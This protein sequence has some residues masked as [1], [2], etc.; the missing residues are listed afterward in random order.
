MIVKI[1][2]GSVTLNGAASLNTINIDGEEQTSA[3]VVF[4][5]TSAAKT[6]LAADVVTA[7]ASARTKATRIVGNALANTI[8]GG[9]GKDT[10]YGGKG[11]DLVDGGK[12]NVRLYGQGGN[13]TLYGGDGNDYI[14]DSAGKNKL[15]GG[16]GNDTLIGGTGNDSLWGDAGADVFLY[17][18]GNGND[19]VF[20]FDDD[21]MLQI[22]GYFTIE[23]SQSAKTITMKMED[24]G[25]VTLKDYTAKDFVVGGDA[26]A[27]VFQ[28]TAKK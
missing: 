22:T 23:Y 17:T 9:T 26:D 7:D 4:V 5:N 10:L 16:A 12:G 28:I 2:D 24:G 25:S 6:T 1:G 19:V 11:N 14:T 18:A 20:G 3:T 21:D 27:G 8:L 13:D 15:Y